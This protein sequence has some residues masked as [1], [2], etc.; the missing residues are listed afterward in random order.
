MEEKEEVSLK[1]LMMSFDGG[2]DASSMNEPE[3]DG[4]GE[5][6]KRTR[7]RWREWICWYY[8]DGWMQEKCEKGRG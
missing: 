1:E 4:H 2:C 3:G 7:W 6:Q 5:S 8:R